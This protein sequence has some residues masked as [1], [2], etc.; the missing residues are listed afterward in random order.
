MIYELVIQG[1]LFISI[2]LYCIHKCVPNTHD[3]LMSVQKVILTHSFEP[4]SFSSILRI[5]G[6][7]AGR[8]GDI[9][10]LD[11]RMT[12]FTSKIFVLRHYR[13][14]IN[15]LI[16]ISDT[17]FNNCF[18]TRRKSWKNQDFLAKE[19]FQLFYLFIKVFLIHK[20]NL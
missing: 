3:K 10:T 17:V 6:V 18:S 12:L 20:I 9:S 1:G 2:V 11:K 5:L 16:I 19:L 8:K 14:V 15:N 4:T 13:N 7:G